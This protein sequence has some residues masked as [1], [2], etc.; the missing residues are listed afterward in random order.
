MFT[1]PLYM[2]FP[3]QLMKCVTFKTRQ[4][5]LQP[6]ALRQCCFKLNANV[7]MKLTWSLLQGANKRFYSHATT[8]T[9][10]LLKLLISACMV[11]VT[12]T[13]LTNLHISMR[14][15]RLELNAKDDRLDKIT[16]LT[17]SDA[18]SSMGD[19]CLALTVSMLTW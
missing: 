6:C 14:Q 8:S 4:N 10:L 18:N 15:C 11:M 5:R 7:S 17:K 12:M 19:Y 9:I 2:T 16:M 13:M 3:L 1:A